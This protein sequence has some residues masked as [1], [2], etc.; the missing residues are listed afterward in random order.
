MG[1]IEIESPL[2]SMCM[3]YVC[4]TVVD[5]KVES[6][7]LTIPLLQRVENAIIILKYWLN[8]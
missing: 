8:S 2:H 3:L 4:V 6:Q 5:K 1:E 7:H